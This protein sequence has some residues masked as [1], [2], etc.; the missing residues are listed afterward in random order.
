MVT[1]EKFNKENYKN[2]LIVTDANVSKL[3]GIAGD[4]IFVL[5]AGEKAKSFFYAQKLCRWFLLNNLQKEQVVVAVGGGS[6]GDVVG[7][8]ASIFK[9]GVRLLH[10]PTTLVAQ[11]DSSIGGKTAVNL[12]GVK[13]AVGTFFFADTLVDVDFLKTLPC[14]QLK[15]GMGE[16]L[17]YRMLNEEIDKIACEGNLQST[18]AACV[19]Y[20]LSIC[21]R[22]S[23]DEGERRLLNFGHSVG[24]AMELRFKLSH[25]EAVANG[26]YYETLIAKKLGLVG[27]DYLNKWQKEIEKHFVLHALTTDVL[28][29][30]K[31]DKKNAYGKICFVLPT[32]AGFTQ[33]F[34]TWEKVQQLFD[35]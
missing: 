19:K 35:D 21:Q 1:F 32:N 6:V 13:N 27:C 5:P 18:I 30:A 29:V 12:D 24:H 14:R 3:Y 33:K 34:L 31:N 11:I 25:G 22:D 7:F 23:F 10:V 4:N 26:L 16:L 28:A 20:K 17:K 9:R 2:N 15:N 8:A